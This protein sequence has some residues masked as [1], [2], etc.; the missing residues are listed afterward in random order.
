MSELWRMPTEEMFQSKNAAWHSGTK[1]H[2][3]DTMLFRHIPDNTVYLEKYD[4]EYAGARY[5]CRKATDVEI[6]QP[7]NWGGAE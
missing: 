7:F 4:I 3:T 5:R 1:W 6:A 2:H